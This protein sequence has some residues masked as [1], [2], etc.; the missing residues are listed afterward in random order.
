[1]DD[2]LIV[3]S[4]SRLLVVSNRTK[5]FSFYS[6]YAQL[7]DPNVTS[8]ESYHQFKSPDFA[9]S[10]TDPSTLGV[11]GSPLVESG[12]M[13]ISELE[14]IV[15]NAMNFHNCTSVKYYMHRREILKFNSSR[16]SE[17]YSEDSD[18]IGLVLQ[19]MPIPAKWWSIYS[20]ALVDL[21]LFQVPNLVYSFTR[22][23]GIPKMNNP[24]LASMGIYT[25]ETIY[26]VYADLKFREVLC[27]RL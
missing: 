11:V 23:D 20:S 17:I 19:N 24:Y 15:L 5:E 1:V 26:Q 16:I 12:F 2:G 7:L 25:L 27:P 22:V 18:S 10:S 21:S 13:S 14:F 6:T 9:D 3:V 4:I 8:R